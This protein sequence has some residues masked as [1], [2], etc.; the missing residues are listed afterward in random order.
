METKT[1]REQV[2]CQRSHNITITRIMLCV[3]E[4]NR[5]VAKTQRRQ[6]QGQAHLRVFLQA[7]AV[8]PVRGQGLLDHA[9]VPQVEVLP[10]REDL[11]MCV[12]GQSLRW[13]PTPLMEP[14]A[15]W[16]QPPGVYPPPTRCP[17]MGFWCPLRVPESEVGRGRGWLGF[18]DI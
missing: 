10:V 9:P 13:D 7:Q 1:E 15:D 3:G 17:G 4:N 5:A 8:A 2:R 12:G 16:G 11:G 14:R 6:P 18:L